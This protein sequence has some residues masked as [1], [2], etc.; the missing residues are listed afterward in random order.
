MNY[1]LSWLTTPQQVVLISLSIVTTLL[2]VYGLNWLALTAISLRRH[3]SRRPRPKEP[4]DWP[5]VSIH[6]PLYN[7]R[8]VA[9]RILDACLALDYPRDRLEILVVDDSNDGTS[10]IVDGYKSK[11]PDLVKVLRR[12]DRS[13]Y[14]AG[15][16]QLALRNSSG[17]FIA[18]FDADYVPPRD[19]LKITIP[20]F[21]EDDRIAFVQTRLG[22]LNKFSSWLTLGASLAMDAHDLID[23]MARYKANL[24]PHFSGTGGVF[25]RAAIESVGGWSPDTLAE[26][27]DLSMR[28]LLGGWKYR[29][30]PEVICP[31]ELPPTFSA[32]KRQQYRWAKGFTECLKKYW[33]RIIFGRGL[34]LPKKLAVLLQLSAYM[35]FPLSA[36]GMLLT[37]PY[38]LVFPM[39]FFFVNYWRLS[40]TPLMVAS[41]AAVYLSPMVVYGTA[42]SKLHE[43]WMDGLRRLACLGAL[44]CG[45]IF[46]NS[47]GV[48]EALLGLR[49]P[50][51]RTPKYG[52]I[53]PRSLEQSLF[54]MIPFG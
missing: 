39:N 51:L 34:S 14:K 36:I 16:L 17:D 42:I 26:D 20:H 47:K 53:D 13:G 8:R 25:R 10:D 12:P 31:G 23:Q 50:F 38:Y 9:S 21:Y 11:F 37:I 35:V 45:I 5:K 44:A 7:E 43:R 28:L 52:Q 32:F 54:E 40:I 4:K 1:P 18:I 33:W 2:G 30:L 41:T 22:Y 24:F 48:L 3:S 15:A 49:S 6:I 27:L 29:Y 46:S 19:F